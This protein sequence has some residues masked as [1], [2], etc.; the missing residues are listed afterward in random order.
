[1]KFRQIV[2]ARSISQVVAIGTGEPRIDAV[3]KLKERYHFLK[4]P[5]RFEELFPSPAPMP[6]GMGAAIAF[7]AGKFT[8]G[9]RTTEIISLQFLPN[10][11]V[12]DMRSSTDDGDL[13]LDEIIADANTQHPESIIRQGPAYYLSQ[14]EVEM[15]KPPDIP[16]VFYEIGREIDRSLSE[17]GLILPKFGFSGVTLSIDQY[18]L[19]ILSPAAFSLE[20]RAG[21]PFSANIFFSQAPVR[22]KDHLKLL[23]KLDSIIH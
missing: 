9:K 19:G 5:E 22:T 15:E 3:I 2:L 23:E 12:A 20:R 11:I 1:M 6:L 7:Q 17:D 13:F 21:F 4:A 14:I 8:N 16:S 10:L 18:E